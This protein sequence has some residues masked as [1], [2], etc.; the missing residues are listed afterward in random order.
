MQIQESYNST[1]LDSSRSSREM[2]TYLF[3]IKVRGGEVHEH[4]IELD[5]SVYELYS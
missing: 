1:K 4:N 2:R 3:E 5:S